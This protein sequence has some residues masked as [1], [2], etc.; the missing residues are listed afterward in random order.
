MSNDVMRPHEG[1]FRRAETKVQEPYDKANEQGITFAQEARRLRERNDLA[2]ADATFVKAASYLRK[3]SE[4]E[5]SLHYAHFNLGVI[6]LEQSALVRARL[7]PERALALL[8]DAE[9]QFQKAL[10]KQLE[11]KIS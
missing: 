5:P 2:K 1:W 6:L 8:D 7:E 9:A 10:L 4:I 11:G 3:A